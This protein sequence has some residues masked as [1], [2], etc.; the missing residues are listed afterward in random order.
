MT[1]HLLDKPHGATRNSRMVHFLTQERAARRNP[2]WAQLD[3]KRKGTKDASRVRQ[4]LRVERGYM[5]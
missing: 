1:R 4:F 5:A 2:L 3:R